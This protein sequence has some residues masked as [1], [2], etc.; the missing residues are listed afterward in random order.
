[1]D[2][3]EIY[4]SLLYRAKLVKLAKIMVRGNNSEDGVVTFDEN[5]ESTDENTSISMYQAAVVIDFIDETEAAT[6]FNMINSS[7]INNPN[8]SQLVYT[9]EGT[10]VKLACF[11]EVTPMF[12]LLGILTNGLLSKLSSSTITSVSGNGW[13]S[14][15]TM[16][17]ETRDD[18]SD[19]H[20]MGWDDGS[21]DR[22]DEEDTDDKES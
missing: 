18:D 16:D 15:V 5:G 8:D 4:I 3:F 13:L 1:M 12:S 11:G 17:P 7:A 2:N 20:G 19:G 6:R 9:R 10:V 21:G 22:Q 14:E